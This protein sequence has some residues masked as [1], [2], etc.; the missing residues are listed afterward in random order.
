[1]EY[2]N[3]L[4]GGSVMP[5]LGAHMQR[6]REGESTLAH[7]QVGSKIYTVA[8][9]TGTSIVAG[10]RFCWAE[11]DIFCVPSWAWHEHAN[12]SASDDACLFSFNDF[13][14]M[15]ALGL[16]REEF[17]LDNDGHQVVSD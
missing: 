16:F 5:T 14:V 8:K 13:P 10:Q 15:R 11:G 9:G 1:M 2:S 12:A 3:P 6:L 17:Y 4:T 7:R